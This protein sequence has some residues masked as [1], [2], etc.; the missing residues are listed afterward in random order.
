MDEN[1][2][3]FTRAE[4]GIY[5][6]GRLKKYPDGSTEL[7]C[8]SRPVFREKGW[9]LREGRPLAALSA[10]RSEADGAAAPEG[11]KGEPEAEGPEGAED[12][13]SSTERAARRAAAKVRDIAL[14]NDFKWF[15]TL[16][17]DAARVDRY[18]VRE[19]TRKLNNWLDNQVRRTGLKYVLVPERHKDG[20]LHFHGLVNDGPGFVS[21]GTWSVPGHKKPIRPR[22]EAQR[23]DWAARDDCHE[24]F[25]WLRWPLGFSTAIPLYGSYQSAVAYVCKYI[26][27]QTGD[28]K[29][30]GRWYYSG[31]ALVLP[32]VELIDY[33]LPE[34]MAAG[35]CEYM[36]EVPEAGLSF[37]M[38]RGKMD[39]GT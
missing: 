5:H 20:A 30:G 27:K 18:D 4:R 8:C 25:N 7:L 19:I 33:G 6:A 10:K 37:G 35:N 29:I 21:S 24:V 12:R 32:E 14:C 22:S 34:L 31:G 11:Q 38:A 13:S 39:G 9:E 3:S 1:K 17:L 15:V 26:R 2:G 28:G 36:F 23:R 16:T